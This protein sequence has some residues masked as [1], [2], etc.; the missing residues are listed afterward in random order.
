MTATHRLD[1]P[2]P[3]PAWAAELVT[4]CGR[5]HVP[6]RE[7]EPVLCVGRYGQGFFI[8]AECRAEEAAELVEQ[9]AVYASRWDR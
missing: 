2:K 1:G 4:P 6:L 8:H 5:C 9:A 3:W 7:G